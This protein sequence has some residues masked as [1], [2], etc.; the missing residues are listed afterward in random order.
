VLFWR[1]DGDRFNLKV[2]PS[3]DNPVFAS[4]LPAVRYGLSI[5][6]VGR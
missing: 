1:L 2:D 3:A 4:R 5:E 6:E